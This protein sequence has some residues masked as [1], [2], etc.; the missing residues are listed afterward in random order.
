MFSISVL[1]FLVMYLLT[2][3]RQYIC[4]K[5]QLADSSCSRIKYSRFLSFLVVF[6]I[7]EPQSSSSFLIF[8]YLY[9]RGFRKQGKLHRNVWV[10]LTGLHL[11]S[12]VLK[13]K[14][15]KP[16][17]FFSFFLQRVDINSNIR[18]SVYLYMCLCV[19]TCMYAAAMGVPVVLQHI[20][21]RDRVCRLLG[22]VSAGGHGR[23][24]GHAAGW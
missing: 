19:C 15:F 3:I 10:D 22:S 2:Y 24:G 17:F 23:S 11:Q 14:Y 6:L 9:L 13:P 12:R 18:A 20:P 21:L 8:T 4:N 7:L 5:L 1:R 16:F